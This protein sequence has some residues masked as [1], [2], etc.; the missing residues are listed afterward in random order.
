MWREAA[1]ARANSRLHAPLGLLVGI[2]RAGVPT[3]GTTKPLTLT[4]ADAGTPVRQGL[5]AHRGPAA[6]DPPV[7]AGRDA[8]FLCARFRELREDLGRGDAGALEHALALGVHL[9][10]RLAELVLEPLALFQQRANLLVHPL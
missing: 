9:A 10:L 5:A 7:V 4:A 8:D 6:S 2:I 1:R 3:D